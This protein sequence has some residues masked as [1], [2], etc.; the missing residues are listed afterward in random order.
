MKTLLLAAML[1][2]PVAPLSA[3]AASPAEDAL[4]SAL[5]LTERRFLGAVLANKEKAALF[6]EDAALAQATPAKKADLVA[7]WRGEAALFSDTYS[8]TAHATR[9][10]GK[11]VKEMVEPAEWAYLMATIRLMEP[12]W[13]KDQ[14]ISMVEGANADLKKGDPDKAHSL[15]KMARGKAA[16]E[17]SD[18]KKTANFSNGLADASRRRREAEDARSQDEEA[19]RGAEEARRHKDELAR[20]AREQA[21]QAARSKNK[22]KTKPIEEASGD[23]GKVFDNNGAP[24]KE[25]PV[26]VVPSESNG[27]ASGKIGLK[28]S[29][30]STPNLVVAPPSPD[31]AAAD[32]DEA[33]LS[34]MKGKSGGLKGK[35]LSIAVPAGGAILG[36]ILGFV[37]GGPLGAVLGALAGAAVAHY[38]KKAIF[39]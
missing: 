4:A 22:A 6:A 2:L 3:S 14:V 29:T 38:A 18:Y 25:E 24:V 32:D 20:K 36:G 37:L 1:A 26:V 33:E 30:P 34:K 11:T 23:A 31:A 5:E 9:E 39:G 13:M 28:P 12:G 21:E 8:K 19:K 17:I 7:K 10:A 15:I 35:I 27:G 16:E